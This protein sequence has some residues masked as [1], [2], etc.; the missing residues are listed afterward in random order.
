MVTLKAN[1]KQKKKKEIKAK[2]IDTYI[3]I[4]TYNVEE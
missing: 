3:N 4:Y 2:N 1:N